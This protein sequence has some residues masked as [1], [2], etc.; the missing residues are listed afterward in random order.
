MEEEAE[1]EQAAA[2]WNRVKCF[3]SRMFI[4]DTST[5]C[6]AAGEG[7]VMEE[8]TRQQPRVNACYQRVREVWRCLPE[9]RLDVRCA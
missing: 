4:E 3:A 6:Q 5:R 2:R 8:G 7:G 9:T 1:L